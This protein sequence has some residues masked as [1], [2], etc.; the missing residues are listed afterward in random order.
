MSY[1][2]RNPF[3]PLWSYWPASLA[4][5]VLVTLTPMSSGYLL[6][7]PIKCRSW[8]GAGS[9]TAVT[10]P[11]ETPPPD[12]QR[13]RTWKMMEVKGVYFFSP[14]AHLGTSRRYISN[15]IGN[16][17]AR[18]RERR[19]VRHTK[20]QEYIE[21]NKHPTV[22]D[23]SVVVLHHITLF[24]L[25][26]IICWIINHLLHFHGNPKSF[27]HSLLPLS[28]LVLT[29]YTPFHLASLSIVLVWFQR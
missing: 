6:P 23:R 16:C 2:S 26:V 13:W 19:A 14:T 22:S 18:F 25:V 5:S 27:I 9:Q 7:S 4:W 12:R 15:R 1:F 17:C 8:A 20:R 24:I 28:F 29:S 3:S 21:N 10:S 11:S